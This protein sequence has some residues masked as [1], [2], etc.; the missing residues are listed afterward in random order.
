MPVRNGLRDYY[1][2][3]SSST[4]RAHGTRRNHRGLTATGHLADLSPA[5]DYRCFNN[6]NV[7]IHAWSW[8]YRSCWHQTCPPV[9]THHCVWIASIASP[10]HHVDKQ[11]CCSSLLPHQ[12]MPWHWAICVPAARLSSGSRFSGSLSRIEP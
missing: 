11:G 12:E 2:G 3:L 5:L 8:N 9:D 7:S 6:S 10:T 1:Q 4:A